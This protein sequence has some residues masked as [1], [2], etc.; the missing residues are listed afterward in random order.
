METAEDYEIVLRIIN[1]L[2]YSMGNKWEPIPVMEM[3]NVAD[4]LDGT[5]AMKNKLIEIVN[6]IK[7]AYINN[8]GRTLE[9]GNSLVLGKRL[10]KGQVTFDHIVGG[11]FIEFYVNGTEETV[12]LVLKYEQTTKEVPTETV[13]KTVQSTAKQLQGIVSTWYFILRNIALLVLMLLL[14]Y[15]GIRIVLGSTAGEKAKYKERI[16]DWLVAV[17]L[18]FVMHYIMVFAVEIVEKITKLI[19]ETVN[20]NMVV[21]ALTEDQEINA[22]KEKD[23]VSIATMFQTDD[24]GDTIY[25]DIGDHGS[26]MW[27]TDLAGAF[28]IQSQMTEE[29]TSSWV[30]YS[31][32]YFVLTLYTLFFAFT[33]GK[34]VLYMAFL[35]MIAPLVAMTYPIDKITDG[36]AQ[37][38][39]AWLKEYI[40]NLMIQ[41]LH[42]LLYTILVT[43]AYTL[44]TESP[45]YALV[46]IGFMMP[47][48]KLMRRFFGFEKA[49]TPGLLGGA[50]GAA[51]AMSGLQG[52]MKG[53]KSGGGNGNK[54]NDKSKDQNKVKMARANNV[55]IMGTIGAGSPRQ[56]GGGTTTVR[57]QGRNAAPGQQ[58][59][60][61]LDAERQ[62]LASERSVL[63]EFEAEGATSDSWTDGDY[64]A[65][66]ELEREQLEQEQRLRMQEQA[67][68][69]N[70]PASEGGNDLDAERQRLASER[71]VLDEFEAEGATS[72]SWTD[73]DYEAFQ[74]LEREQL[75]QEERLR[76]QEQNNTGN[77][78]EQINIDEGQA[79]TDQPQLPDND[80][81]ANV[82]HDES[83]REHKRHIWGAVGTAMVGAGKQMAVGALTG[84]HPMKFAGRVA[85][86]AA[87]GAI[88]LGLGVASGDPNKAF[89]YT[90][91]GAMAGSAF[92]NSLSNTKLID[93]NEMKDDIQEAY[94]GQDYQ[95]KMLDKERVKFEKD[96]QNLEY[97]RKTLK[98]KDTESAKRVME[99]TGRQCFNNGITDIEDIAT[100]HQ[101]KNDRQNPMSFEYAVAARNYA[102]K[103]LPTDTKSMSKDK[104]EKYQ[105]TWEKEFYDKGYHQNA[106]K[107]AEDA[108]N[109][110]VRFNQAKSKLKDI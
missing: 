28:R 96:K 33:Y 25:E 79:S 48:E 65:F 63:D 53:N 84:I 21:I 100:I 77:D 1:E 56:P 18:I 110:A 93:G 57:P 39:D 95:R 29:G 76:L 91:A 72:D 4:T 105:K 109:A 34:R 15:S 31:F 43:S 10:D 41:P 73:G 32:C 80:N 107:L 17:C 20:G 61:D 11:G 40:F 35:T 14:I 38:F 83:G 13:T 82:T 22:R 55:D 3:Y 106:D 70:N 102:K 104:I 69:Q 74:E 9:T 60:S 71:S 45:V 81:S 5:G 42:L 50:A 94:Y 99:D 59:G 37:A 85:A 19:G 92:A 51:I 62:R 101:L 68:G 78:V 87:V 108:W 86:G 36:K 52:I 75:E 89:Q 46:A 12:Y 2:C 98:L 26:L 7:T 54:G 27:P 103:R 8:T 47:A 90:T 23:G 66:Q 44:A 88:G 97:L 58:G 64:E 30:G 16:M 49:K 24:D 6:S 67:N